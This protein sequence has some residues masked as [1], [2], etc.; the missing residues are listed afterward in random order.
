M[1]ANNNSYIQLKRTVKDSTFMSANNN[2]YLIKEICQGGKN[3]TRARG[4]NLRYKNVAFQKSRVE[5]FFYK[6]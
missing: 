6:N 5:N 1:S 3:C 4:T 2:F